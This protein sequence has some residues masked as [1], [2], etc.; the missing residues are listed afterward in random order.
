VSILD[1]SFL[2]MGASTGSSQT[3][4]DDEKM[5]RRIFFHVRY[6]II[7]TVDS[8]GLHYMYSTR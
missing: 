1:C 3:K 8:I 5:Y 7:T 4:K 2:E 6:V